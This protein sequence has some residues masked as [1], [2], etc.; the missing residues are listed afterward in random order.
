MLAHSTLLTLKSSSSFQVD[1]V[2]KC[3]TTPAVEVC[4]DLL[5]VIRVDRVGGGVGF[6]PKHFASGPQLLQ[7][8][9]CVWNCIYNIYTA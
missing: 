9:V 6:P 7:V 4:D 3:N 5:P 2:W 8:C 1:P